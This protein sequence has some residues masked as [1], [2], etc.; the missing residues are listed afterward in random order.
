MMIAL[1]HVYPS[2]GD[3]VIVH[4]RWWYY[5]YQHGFHGIAT[6]NDATGADYTSVW[7]F[8][9][10]IFDKL[11]LYQHLHLEY[12]IKGL[13]AMGTIAAG[14][15]VYFIVKTLDRN[16]GSWKP[17]VAASLVPFLPAF[18][19][20]ILKTNMPDSIYLALDLFVLLAILRRRPILAWF[21]LGI[22]MSFK[23]MAVYIVPFLILVYFIR[24][25]A[26][27]VLQRLAPV[28]ALVGI[29]V[30]SLPGI[31]AGQGIYE[32]TIGTMIMRGTTG[33][34]KGG[35]WDI[36]FTPTWSV[37][38]DVKYDITVSAGILFGFAAIVLVIGAFV[39]LLLHAK[40]SESQLD[41][42]FDLL[43]AAPIVFFSLLPSQHE[44]YWS[45]ASVFAMLVMLLRWSRSSLVVF[46]LLSVVSVEMYMGARLPP[47]VCDYLLLAVVVYMF[48]RVFRASKL[49]A[50]FHEITPNTINW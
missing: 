21:L 26:M 13:A 49:S 32:A 24:F 41:G 48:V 44:A 47:L 18:F 16:P 1:R 2:A 12:C 46:L 29:L 5:M 9:I 37:M 45:L 15:A 42:S 17:V 40:D 36:L 28:F 50:R 4:I 25:A 20:D 11:G 23:L 35:L 10:F 30:A 6:I 31:F 14:I 34:L 8:I 33:S 22:A 19:L 27:T 38:P 7:Y 39:A 3:M 43:V